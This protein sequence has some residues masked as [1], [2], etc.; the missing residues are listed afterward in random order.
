MRLSA[1]LAAAL[2]VAS[3]ILVAQAGDG[4]GDSK[5]GAGV[6]CPRCH[7]TCELSVSKDEVKKS[8][9]D[10]ECKTICVPR[11]T[12]PWQKCGDCGSRCGGKCG[13]G[14]SD[15]K[16]G[17]LDCNLDCAKCGG[18]KACG[19]APCARAKTVRTLKKVEYTCS[20]CKYK[21]TPTDW[22]SCDGCKGEANKVPEGEPELG[23]PPPPPV[24][25]QQLYG[26]PAIARN[27]SVNP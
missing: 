27:V 25:A 12:F 1:I 10:V 2:L 19:A 4:C 20:H 23:P 17:D 18:P 24:S 11:I 13:D 6:R 8:C 14:K 26:K 9:W 5:C 7:G 3:P 22:K 16:C 21:W 15:G